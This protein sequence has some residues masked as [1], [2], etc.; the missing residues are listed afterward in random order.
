MIRRPPRSTLFPY[1]TLFRSLMQADTT[2]FGGNV[3]F[4]DPGLTAMALLQNNTST[5]ALA[6]VTFDLVFKS[7]IGG[8]D[9]GGWA[10]APLAAITIP[11]G[12][13]AHLPPKPAL[14]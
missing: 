7:R 11:R 6:R 2:Q 4:P 10:F 5:G 12:D 13:S 1:T 9:A 8:Y 3:L 14:R